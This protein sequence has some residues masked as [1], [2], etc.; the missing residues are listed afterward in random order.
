MR[1]N[2][3]GSVERLGDQR[4]VTLPPVYGPLRTEKVR[5]VLE[6]TEIPEFDDILFSVTSV[7]SVAKFLIAFASVVLVGATVLTTM[8]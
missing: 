4:F 7:T 2:N 5:R 6:S 3:F 1:S 8:G